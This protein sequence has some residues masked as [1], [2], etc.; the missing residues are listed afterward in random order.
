MYKPVKSKAV[1]LH[2]MVAHGGR[3]GIAPTHTSPRDGDEW[4]ASCPGRALPPGKGPP[5]PLDRRLGRPQSRTQGLEEKS[6]VPVGDRTP[7][8]QSAV[9]HCTAWATAAPVCLYTPL[10][11][12]CYIFYEL[13]KT[14]IC[15]EEHVYLKSITSCSEDLSRPERYF[16]SL[17][18]MLV[19]SSGYTFKEDTY[20]CWIFFL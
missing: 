16:F 13:V 7:I 10:V 17:L 4:S 1:P 14:L 19:S 12:Y 11:Y 20:S 6:S 18:F 2:A 9:R 5:I 15:C 3:G 8:V